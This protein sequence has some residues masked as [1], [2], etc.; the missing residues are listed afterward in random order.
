[1]RILHVNHLLDPVL[2]G[3]TAER[4]FRLSSELA[5]LGAECTILTMDIGESRSRA[6]RIPRLQVEALPCIHP[7]FFL[8]RPPLGKIDAL[9]KAV[10]IVQMFGN[11]T[12]LNFLVWRACRRHGKPFVFCPAGALLPFGRSLLL[13]RIYTRWI[14]R[15]LIRDAARCL[16]VTDNERDHFLSLGA[17]E[18]RLETIPNGI[19]PEQYRLEN[20]ALQIQEFRHRIGIGAAPFIFFLGRLNPIKGPDLLLDAFSAVAGK[21][22][23]HHLVFGGPDAGMLSQ[24][25][26]MAAENGLGDRIH[27]LGFVNARTKAVALHAAQLLV[28]PSR[29]EAMSIVVLEAGACGCPVLFTDTC[30][31]NM[32]QERGAGTMVPVEANAI[33]TALD[34]LLDQ[35]AATRI[36][37]ERLND[38]VTKEFLWRDQANRC[39]ALYKQILRDAPQAA[40][41]PRG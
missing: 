14:S 38:L 29:S 40:G 39:L 41:Q 10:D 25:R 22:P 9:V 20:P 15:G 16:C 32:F 18:G 13:K 7:R 33:A 2:G 24:L 3:G 21:W 37:G 4:T 27:F 26:Q 17:D 12:I 30:G 36:Q 31:L 5:A 23:G 35:P 1:M 34:R 8:P 6:A 19:D 11:W 28:I